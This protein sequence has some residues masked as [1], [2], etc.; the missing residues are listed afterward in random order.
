MKIEKCQIAQAGKTH[1]HSALSLG[2]DYIKYG[3]AFECA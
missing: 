2:K 1:P 3:F